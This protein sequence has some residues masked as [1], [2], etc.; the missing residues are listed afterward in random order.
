MLRSSYSGLLAPPSK[1]FNDLLQVPLPSQVPST[2]GVGLHVVP[3]T[4]YLKQV[5]PHQLFW[6]V[7]VSVQVAEARV[8]GQVL[9]ASACTG[10][11]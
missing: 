5:P 4:L 3:L 1:E 7:S 9:H 8:V 2:P 10:V 6:L 11:L